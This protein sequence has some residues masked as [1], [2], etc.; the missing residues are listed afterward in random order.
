MPVDQ[1]RT[2]ATTHS[3]LAESVQT[4]SLEVCEGPASG[5]TARSDSAAFTIGSQGNCDLVLADPTVSRFHCEIRISEGAVRL[6]DTG[7][8]NGTFIDGV[9]VDAGHLRDGSRVRVGRSIIAVAFV[10]KSTVLPLSEGSS[11]GNLVG[12]SAAMRRTFSFM[13][14]AARTDATVLLAGET[15]TGKSLAARSIHEEGSR[16]KRPF[17]LV[18]CGAIPANLIESE[19]FGHERGAF[20]GA[21][22]HRRGAF[23][24]AHGGTLFLDEIG[25]LPLELQ[26]KLLGVLENGSVRR[27][28][29]NAVREF[30]VRLITASNRD[31][32]REV[33][34]GRFRADLYYRLGVVRIEI[35]PLRQRGDD[36]PR[37]AE[38]LL[39]K[40][41]AD[42][43][44]VATLLNE[45]M[46][47]RLRSSA[48]PG[49][50]R[51]LRNY[52]ERCLVF[53]EV[54]PVDDGLDSSV[55]D[56]PSRSYQE[57]RQRA[58]ENFERAYVEALL[59]RHEGQVTAAAAAA[60][61]NRAYL[62]RL[63][64]RH[65]LRR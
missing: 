10:G 27:V 22:G 21:T 31:L 26:P 64:G 42:Q 4:L 60:G 43:A 23:E 62:Y 5:T 14:R 55:V 34:T 24:E 13:E 33:N 65:G 38:H 51:E 29:S 2:L 53:E 15:G 59:A 57:A 6:V 44:R 52:L 28:G 18:D 54:L 41:G 39:S 1:H 19:L 36:I 16:G 17:V 48:W 11:F 63:L 30:D 35:P 46:L 47:D 58:I 40:L 37:L 7:S 56:D 12:H 32:R 49:N 25:E 3:D 50:I 8:R 20:T 9:R 45:K 61:M